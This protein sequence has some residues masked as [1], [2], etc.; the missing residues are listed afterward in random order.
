MLLPLNF[1]QC[2]N[3]KSILFMANFEVA[4]STNIFFSFSLQAQD[5]ILADRFTLSPMTEY[6]LLFPL[7]PTTPAKTNPDEMPMLHSVFIFS[8]Q[9]S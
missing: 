9:T 7:V 8:A 6:S 3:L 1:F 5:I 4:S 2:Q